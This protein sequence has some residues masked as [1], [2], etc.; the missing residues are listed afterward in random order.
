MY[1]TLL[2]LNINDLESLIGKGDTLFMMKRY[3]ESLATYEQV[4]LVDN[5]NI[6][7]LKIVDVLQKY[8]SNPKGRSNKF[9]LFKV[10]FTKRE[11]LTKSLKKIQ[12]I[13]IVFLLSVICYLVF[14]GYNGRNNIDAFVRSVE[15]SRLSSNFEEALA[16]TDKIIVS[17]PNS[18]IGYRL[19][20]DILFELERYEEAKIY[21]DKLITDNQNDVGLYMLK[22][23][24][25]GESNQKHEAVEYLNIYL[26]TNPDD[27]F[28]IRYRDKLQKSLDNK[29]GS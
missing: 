5:D 9:S 28:I 7:V 6:A 19:K 23:I 14:S 20:I 26:T 24:A 2:T 29:S 27:D 12:I 11:A 25:F 10:R 22:G 15:I 17:F 4:L 16:G 8:L 1:D 21:I 3:Q 13:F 18:D